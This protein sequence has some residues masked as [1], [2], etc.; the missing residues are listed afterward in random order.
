M[1]FEFAFLPALGIAA[2]MMV[3]SY[4]DWAGDNFRVWKRRNR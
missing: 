1:S 4:D 3:F 2:I